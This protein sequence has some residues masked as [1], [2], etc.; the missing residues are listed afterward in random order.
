MVIL[1][2]LGKLVHDEGY[3]MEAVDVGLVPE[4]QEVVAVA[5]IAKGADIVTIIKSA[6]F[7]RF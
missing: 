1:C 6:A 4:G 3:K 2:K 7:K 5:G